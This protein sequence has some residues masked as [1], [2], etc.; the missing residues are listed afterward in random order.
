M[1]SKT[2]STAFSSWAAVLAEK[3]MRRHAMAR[4]LAKMRQT[5][6]ATAFERWLAYMEELAG[7]RTKLRK[8]AQKMRNRGLAAAFTGWAV[9]LNG[10]TLLRGG[11]VS[12]CS[13]LHESKQ[14]WPAAD[15]PPGR[16]DL[17]AQTVAEST[18]SR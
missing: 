6:Y 17:S 15:P 14:T 8:C 3:R 9:L 1:L 4:V 11:V 16:S 5:H 12:A 13:L 2:I 10:W 18:A 7:M